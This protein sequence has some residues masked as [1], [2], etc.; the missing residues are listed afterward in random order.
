[1]AHVHHPGGPVEALCGVIGVVPLGVGPVLF[2]PL[3]GDRFDEPG[4][5]RETL[6]VAERV[7][8]PESETATDPEKFPFAE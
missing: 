5:T 1:M 3:P 2:V 6:Q 8:P 4:A 7:T